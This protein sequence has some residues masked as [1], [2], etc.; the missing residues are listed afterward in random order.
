MPTVA[1]KVHRNKDLTLQPFSFLFLKTLVKFL[2]NTV[3][4]SWTQESLLA[5]CTSDIRYLLHDLTLGF[6]LV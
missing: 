4:M 3:E 5:Y 6:A 2:Q 1:V